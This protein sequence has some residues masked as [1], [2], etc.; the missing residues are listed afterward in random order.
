[1]PNSSKLDT[2]SNMAIFYYPL[3]LIAF[4]Y[5]DVLG[6]ALRV[7]AEFNNYTA[8]LL[9][10]PLILKTFFRPLKNEYREGLVVFSIVTGV[11]IKSFLLLISISI[12]CVFLLIELIIL[13]LL[14]L[15]PFSFLLF[16]K[17]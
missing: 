12:I 9:S 13:F 17:L 8:S 14:F 7:F 2:G 1:V 10:L 6:G 4:W 3:Y 16:F 5:T 15:L 11:V